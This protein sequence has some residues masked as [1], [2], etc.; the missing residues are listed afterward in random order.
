MK[1]NEDYSVITNLML[2]ATRARSIQIMGYQRKKM[3]KKHSVLL[4]NT[5]THTI[6]LY[7][8]STHQTNTKQEGHHLVATFA[9]RYVWDDITSFR[10]RT[11]WLDLRF[12]RMIQEGNSR[13]LAI[14]YIRSRNLLGKDLDPMYDSSPSSRRWFVQ[15]IDEHKHKKQDNKYSQYN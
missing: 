7:Q 4:V 1:K 2:I 13:H 12:I 9:R 14:E 6:D 5:Q 3:S 10:Y 15:Q 11:R 8:K